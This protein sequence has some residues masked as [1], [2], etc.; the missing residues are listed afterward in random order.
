M[1]QSDSHLK[2]VD[3]ALQI[4][5]H[6][7]REHP[8]WKASELAELLGLHRSIVYRI[9]KTLARRGFVTQTDRYSPYRLGLKLIEL[10]NVV[11]RD[12]ELREIADPIMRELVRETGESVTLTVLSGDECV[13]VGKVNSPHPIRAVT[14]IGERFPLHAGAT[15]KTLMAHLDP[16]RIDEV[17]AQGLKPAT[18]RTVTDPTQLRMELNEIRQQGWA[19]SMGE[20]TP[21]VAAIAAPLRDS[22]GEVVASI[23]IGFVASRYSEDRLAV[24]VKAV[25][26]AAEQI[27]SQLQVWHKP[28]VRTQQ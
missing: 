2:T 20:L 25:R 19:F 16:G 9:L 22:N 5:L 10:G 13:C 26:R 8:E 28:A 1:K 23:S 14:D 15:A 12:M 21:D 18:S 7:D 3:R 27:S 24:L 4:L 17:I 6:F 11:L